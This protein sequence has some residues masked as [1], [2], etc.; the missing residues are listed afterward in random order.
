MRTAVLL[1]CFVVVVVGCTAISQVDDLHE[2][3]PQD[4]TDGGHNANADGSFT[5]FGQDDGGNDAD[6]PNKSVLP[7]P[8]DDAGNPLDLDGGSIDGCLPV[9]CGTYG[10]DQSDAGDGGG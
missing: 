8:T 9:T 7:Q 3:S 2:M 6:P 10:I 1:G 5:S 4:I